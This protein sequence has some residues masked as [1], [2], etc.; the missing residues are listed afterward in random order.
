MN[1]PPSNPAASARIPR[2]MAILPILFILLPTAAT[3]SETLR[4]ICAIIERPAATLFPVL[5]ILR[6]DHIDGPAGRAA[7]LIGIMTGLYLIANFA[8]T[9]PRRFKSVNYSLVTAI[10]TGSGAQALSPHPT[11]RRIRARIRVVLLALVIFSLFA[12]MLITDDVD[13][14]IHWAK[15]TSPYWYALRP[16]PFFLG[17]IL[18]GQ[19]ILH[20]P[21]IQPLGGPNRLVHAILTGLKLA[22]ILG[23]DGMF[24]IALIIILANLRTI[25]Q[26]TTRDLASLS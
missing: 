24:L 3:Q 18:S 7:I 8:R 21:I 15:T 5:A 25:H 10:L 20:N 17:S 23:G 16:T 2:R 14:Y 6:A 11:K 1:Q 12:L 19:G 26:N 22:V 13:G 9:I 4:S